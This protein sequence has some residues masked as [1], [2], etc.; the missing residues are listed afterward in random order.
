MIN[1][2]NNEA[3]IPRRHHILGMNYVLLRTILE[4]MQRVYPLEGIA[5]GPELIEV[6]EKL[7][8]WCNAVQTEMT[9]EGML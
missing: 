6:H 4:G 2:T 9:K 5:T 3:A 7:A 1:K 8:G